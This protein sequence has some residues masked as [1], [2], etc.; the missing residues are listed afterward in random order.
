MI[1]LSKIFNQKEPEEEKVTAKEEK[2]VAEVEVVS[3]FFPSAEEV[4]N[5]INENKEIMKDK[6][7]IA[8]KDEILNEIN[9]SIIKGRDHAVVL[10][11]LIDPKDKQ[12]LIS[13][14]YRV[15]QAGDFGES[16]Y[17]SWRLES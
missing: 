3:G 10:N 11:H 17:I 13:I 15:S 7:P 9:E 5:L 1:K 4:R 8:T 12:E 2:N 14:G 16:I 6:Y